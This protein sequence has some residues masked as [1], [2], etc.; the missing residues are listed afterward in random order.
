LNIRV[1]TLTTKHLKGVKAKVVY[2]RA[3]MAMVSE[4]ILRY[5]LDIR[6]VLTIFAIGRGLKVKSNNFLING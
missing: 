4:E 1:E 6:D 5:G 2:V 3:Q